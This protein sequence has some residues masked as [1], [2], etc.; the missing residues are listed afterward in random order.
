MFLDD[1][2]Y[3]LFPIATVQFQIRLFERLQPFVAEVR[4]LGSACLNV[5]VRACS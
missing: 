4:V 3:V 1:I 5:R 2:I